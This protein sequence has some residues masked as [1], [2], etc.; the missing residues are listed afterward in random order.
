MD[1]GSVLLVTW[2]GTGNQA[3][4]MS[5]NCIENW[6]IVA[7]HDVGCMNPGQATSQAEV[8]VRYLLSISNGMVHDCAGHI[9]TVICTNT[10]I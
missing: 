4:I 5:G 8:A 1:N 2:F 3:L 9:R 7:S 10:V 6:K